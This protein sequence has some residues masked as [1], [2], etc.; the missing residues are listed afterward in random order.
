MPDSSSA[1]CSTTPGSA[2]RS[3]SASCSSCRS[4]IA[5]R[6]AGSCWAWTA[7]ASVSPPAMP[8]AQAWVVLAFDF[9]LRR[10]GVA[11]GD[12]VS[13]TAAP[14]AAVRVTGHG[15]DWAA[16]EHL[17]HEYQPQLL[18]VGSPRHADGSLSNL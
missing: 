4:K 18:V 5:G 7:R 12:T 11:S 15:I 1:K 16:I 17:L 3:T 9:G 13:T 6:Q 8:E 14:R 10:I 2:C